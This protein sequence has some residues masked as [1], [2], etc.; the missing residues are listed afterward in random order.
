MNPKPDPDVL[1]AKMRRRFDR[2]HPVSS[3]GPSDGSGVSSWSVFFWGAAIG[4]A[5]GYWWATH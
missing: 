1:L 2:A 4:F 5:A 3:S